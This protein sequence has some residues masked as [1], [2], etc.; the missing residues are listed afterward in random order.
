[1]TFIVT[2]NLKKNKKKKR[3][4]REKSTKKLKSKKLKKI[5]FVKK[6]KFPV[7]FCGSV[8]SF[9]FFFH[10]TFSDFWCFSL[11]VF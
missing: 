11:L 7:E 9:F 4:G 8:S 5:F 1:V 10:F 3:K 6:K 2:I